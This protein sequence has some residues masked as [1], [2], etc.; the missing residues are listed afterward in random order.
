MG[1]SAKF[2]VGQSRRSDL[3]TATSGLTPLTGHQ[4]VSKVP[5]P[6]ISINAVESAYALNVNAQATGLGM[7]V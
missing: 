6:A 2:A 3:V 7:Q 4:H 1:I 5:E